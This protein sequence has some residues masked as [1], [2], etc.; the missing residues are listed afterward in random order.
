MVGSA[1]G[2]WKDV[3]AEAAVGLLG[4]SAQALNQFDCLFSRQGVGEEEA[5]QSLV[6]KLEGGHASAAQPVVERTLALFGDAIGL[7]ESLRGRP[8]TVDQRR[9]T[10]GCLLV[11]CSR[12]NAIVPQMAGTHSEIAW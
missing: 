10:I 9:R 4:V 2:E 7:G 11:F 1:F 6:A 3:L 12:M 8:A 5:Q